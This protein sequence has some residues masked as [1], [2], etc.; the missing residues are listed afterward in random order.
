MRVSRLSHRRII[1]AARLLFAMAA[2]ALLSGC[3]SSLAVGGPGGVRIVKIDSV[4][5]PTGTTLTVSVLID[6]ADGIAGGDLIITFNAAQVTAVGA[7]TTSLT[8]GF[9]L[10]SNPQPGI[11]K[12]SFASPT[13]IGGGSGALV[14]LQLRL[15]P[16]VGPGT[17]IVLALRNDSLLFDVNGAVIL[18]QP[19]NGELCAP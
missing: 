14:D 13:A 11:I 17:C 6:N 15:A 4:T 16:G 18:F 5:G 1:G 8:S 3:P 19:Q 10:S 12:V 7:V 9:L 2:L